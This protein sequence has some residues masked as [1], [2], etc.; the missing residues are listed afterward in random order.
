MCHA[1]DKIGWFW[2]INYVDSKEGL[3][4]CVKRWHLKWD[5]NDKQELGMERYGE[6]TFHAEGRFHV[7]GMFEKQKEDQGG[8]STE[9]N[10]TDI[11]RQELTFLRQDVSL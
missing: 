9:K 10:M 2:E 4:I 1:E 11:E 3:G 8:R 7:A 6:S 5:L